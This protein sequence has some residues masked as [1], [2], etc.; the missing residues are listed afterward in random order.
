[1]TADE[2]KGIVTLLAVGGGLF[3]SAIKRRKRLQLITDMPRSKT[4]SAPQGFVE[5]SGFA[6]PAGETVRASGDREAV[7][8]SFVLEKQITTGTRKTKRKE[9][10]PVFTKIHLS[11]FLLVDATGVAMLLVGESSFDL[12]KPTKKNWRSLPESEQ[13]RLRT[14]VITEAVADF[15]PSK[16]MFG[17]FSAPFRIVENQILVGSPLHA[18]GHFDADIKST[19]SLRSAGLTE[20]CQKVFHSEARSVRKLTTVLDENRDG[21]VSA[22]EAHRG[23][24]MAAKLARLK[25]GGELITETEY[26]VH[27]SL[28][29]SESHP[30]VVADVDE[31]NLRV[32]LNRWLWPQFAG[33]AAMIAAAMTMTITGFTGTG[34]A[35]KTGS[36]ARAR[37][38]QPSAQHE[39][40]PAAK[41]EP[42]I[43]VAAEHADCVRG[44]SF[45]CEELL[46]HRD[47]LQLSAEHIT[48]Y[49][50]RACA[51][52]AKRFCPKAAPA[53]LPSGISGSTN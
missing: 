27:G 17:L 14:E 9:W 18:T 43:N 15:P 25:A 48:Y 21:K 53:H 33:G 23:Y 37:H 42:T 36:S 29:S 6:W 41:A 24:S 47:S 35:A 12:S 51:L 3:F 26:Q 28:R 40:I 22:Q 49:S 20:F 52:G 1:M 44:S 50:Q 45:A 38:S 39:R 2:I 19:E 8:Y 4:E 31:A 13:Q 16:L 11:P 34:F 30:L 10:V 7:Y 32:R 5:L 46:N